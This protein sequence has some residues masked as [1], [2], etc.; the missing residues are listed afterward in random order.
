MRRVLPLVMLM[1]CTT[2]G[3]AERRVA[4]VFANDGGYVIEPVV[5]E[6]SAT[7]LYRN[8][9]R[10]GT[11][12]AGKAK[13]ISCVSNAAV[14]TIE[15][16]PPEEGEV[17]LATN[18]EL[19]QRRTHDRELTVEEAKSLLRYAR[20]FLRNHDVDEKAL[21]E[22]DVNARVM[23]VG[24]ELLIV[25]SWSTP[26]AACAGSLF[27]IARVDDVTSENVTPQVA[28]YRSR[29]DCTDAAY[30]E[31]LDH[32]DIDGDGFDEVIT[33]DHQKEGYDYLIWRRE[34]GG[35]WAVSRRAGSGC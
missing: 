34:S 18:F 33:R 1:M 10:A 8:G 32:I 16:T 25:G 2:L 11:V 22:L 13:A 17:L 35:R 14:A 26:D 3:A 29:A 24:D 21:A 31:P 19:P 5:G 23:G 15:G 27:L 28:R 12:H 6:G 7:A 30:I 4:A 9:M 20:A